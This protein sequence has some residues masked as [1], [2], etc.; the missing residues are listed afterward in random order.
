M[1]MAETRARDG[2]RI[3][4]TVDP[5]E[6]IA[7]LSAR[8]AELHSEMRAVLDQLVGIDVKQCP[9]VPSGVLRNLRTAK[10]YYGLCLCRWL[11]EEHAGNGDDE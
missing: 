8:A 2:R 7:A 11:Q 9:G 1:T 4:K 3:L 5:M 6:T 10:H